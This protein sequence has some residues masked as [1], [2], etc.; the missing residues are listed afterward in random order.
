MIHF[1]YDKIIAASI[2]VEPRCDVQSQYCCF[3]FGRSEV[4]ISAWRSAIEAETFSWFSLVC[5]G[6]FQNSV[7]S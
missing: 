7:L 1:P 5:Q 2:K 4:Q 6:I 3:V